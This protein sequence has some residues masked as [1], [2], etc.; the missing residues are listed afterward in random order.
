MIK[1][2]DN[3][4][5]QSQKKQPVILQPDGIVLNFFGVEDASFKFLD[6][7]SQVC[8]WSYVSAI[9]IKRVKNLSRSCNK[10]S[11]EI[12]S[13]VFARR[14][15]F[16]TYIFWTAWTTILSIFKNTFQSDANKWFLFLR[17]KKEVIFIITISNIWALPTSILF[18]ENISYYHYL[19]STSHIT[20]RYRLIISIIK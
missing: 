16:Q 19:L 20:I 5:W 9:V 2:F 17:N 6:S 11:F 13:S 18:K 3:I 14:K 7:L 1:V 4:F 8:L 12:F 10:P 15:I